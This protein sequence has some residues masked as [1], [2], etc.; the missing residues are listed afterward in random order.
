MFYTISIPS[1]T[2]CYHCYSVYLIYVF[3]IIHNLLSTFVKNF[4]STNNTLFDRSMI[5]NMMHTEQNKL[6]N[7]TGKTLSTK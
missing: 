2:S 4:I 7:I 5:I 3:L 6:I 1:E